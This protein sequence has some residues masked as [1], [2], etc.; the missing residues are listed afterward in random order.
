M[1]QN[2]L[3]LHRSNNP[4]YFLSQ[5][6][7]DFIV[8]RTIHLLLFLQI[9]HLLKKL[10]FFGTFNEISRWFVTRYLNLLTSLI[11]LNPLLCMHTCQN[12]ELSFN[13]FQF[14]NLRNLLPNQIS[15]L[16]RFDSA[17]IFKAYSLSPISFKRVLI[18]LLFYF[19]VTSPWYTI[20]KT[21][22]VLISF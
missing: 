6:Y 3:F 16:V 2:A 19:R 13:Y 17:I 12:F 22:I 4:N 1:H 9:L 10:V 21:I 14:F 18:P 20:F 7:F 11:I 5:H 8:F 15:L